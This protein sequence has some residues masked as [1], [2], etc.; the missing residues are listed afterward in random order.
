ML[1]DALAATEL[2]LAREQHLTQLDGL[3]AAAAHEL[4]TPLA[5]ITLVVKEM[6]RH[7]AQE[8][9]FGDDVRL[10]AQEVQRCRTI[11]S[12]IASLGDQ[13]GGMFDEM[14]LMHLVEEVVSPHRDFGVDLLIAT[15]GLGPEPMC[16]RNPGM[17]YGLGNL[18]ENA[19]DF[20][21]SEVR[22]QAAWDEATVSLTIEDNGPGFSPDVLMRL[23]EP[24]VT[25]RGSGRRAKSE[26]ASGLGLGLF[27]AKTLLER[28]GASVTPGNVD[29]P[30]GGAMVRVVWPRA[31]F[32]RKTGATVLGEG[33][34]AQ[35]GPAP[36]L[37]E[38]KAEE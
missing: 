34:G 22:I 23:G 16:R 19:L 37:P 1:S 33:P 14:S 12:K 8:G 35:T 9:P 13:D 38:K 28:S 4:G 20:A 10:V 7:G 15:D 32:E 29:M 3:A 21:R 24:Y 27:I 2:V 36:G 31:I 26:E 25:S 11:L 30:G 18:V 5:T 17:V 6:L